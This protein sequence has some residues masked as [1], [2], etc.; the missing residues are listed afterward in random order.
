MAM[1]GH[2]GKNESHIGMS[3]SISLN[4]YES[5]ANEIQVTQ[6][7]SPIDILIQRDQNT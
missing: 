5:N 7:L 6:S 2:N 3:A 1:S 4:L